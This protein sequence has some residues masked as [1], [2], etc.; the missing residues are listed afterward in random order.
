MI[1]SDKERS[2]F[3]V[4]FWAA[5]LTTSLNINIHPEPEG[6]DVVREGDCLLGL[7]GAQDGVRECVTSATA[8]RQGEEVEKED[9]LEQ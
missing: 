5:T 6:P 9:G 4:K 8:R 1:C 7:E 3:F 2:V